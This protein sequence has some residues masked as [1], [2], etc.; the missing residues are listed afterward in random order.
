[1]KKIYAMP[2]MLVAVLLVGLSSAQSVHG[3]NGFVDQ[4]TLRPIEVK[5]IPTPQQ[6]LRIAGD[7]AFTVPAGKL[8]VV[9][10]VA[11]T[12]PVFG[13][14]VFGITVLFDGVDVVSASLLTQNSPFLSETG[15]AVIPPGVTAPAGTVITVDDNDSG[16]MELGICLGYI[17]NA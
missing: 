5:G 6:M 13:T 15:V 3:P 12:S 9:T 14:S 11:T 2:A 8:F 7:E 10:G 1:M 16:K 4:L 17:V